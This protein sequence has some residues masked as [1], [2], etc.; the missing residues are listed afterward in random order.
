MRDSLRSGFVTSFLAATG[1]FLMVACAGRAASHAQTSPKP[2]PISEW[3]RPARMSGAATP[4][5]RLDRKEKPDV[6]QASVPC[7]A[8]CVEPGAADEGVRV[9]L[10]RGMTL[11]SL[12]REYGVPVETIIEVNAIRDPSSIRAGTEIYIPTG[13]PAPP[14]GSPTPP[15]E[16][17]RQ[18]PRKARPK[19]TEK[20]PEPEAANLMSIAWPLDGLITGR[21]GQRGKHHHHDGIDIDGVR[22]EEV[23]AVA[24]GIVVRSGSEGNYGKTVVIDHGGGLSTLYAHA[25]RLL[26]NEGETVEQGEAIAEV[27]ATGNAHGTHL[28]FEVRRDGQ[29]VDPLPYL[30]PE[31]VGARSSH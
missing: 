15:A 4:A 20:T 30:K 6:E 25:S 23:H 7:G 28:H 1:A 13:G 31:M 18:T 27:G 9:N 19:G 12:S 5:V 10:D 14:A 3:E 22:G 11:Y 24:S 26:V 16:P 29:P 8:G 2:P 21:F 17:P